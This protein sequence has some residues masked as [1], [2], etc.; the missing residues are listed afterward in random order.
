MR[1]GTDGGRV[2]DWEEK[3]EEKLQPGHTINK[4]IKKKIFRFYFKISREMFRR[5]RFCHIGKSGK[6]FS[7]EFS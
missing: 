3:R 4:L 5:E 1:V 7:Y 2:R 6:L